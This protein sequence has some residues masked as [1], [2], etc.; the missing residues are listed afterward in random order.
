MADQERG[1]ASRHL[2]LLFEAGT[3]VGLT[4]GQLLDLFLARRD[5]AAFSALVERHGTMVLRVCLEVL[6]NDHD[7]HDAFQ[8]TFVV[9][10]RR[11]ASINRRDSL[12]SW[13]YGVARRVSARERSA[14]ARR[15]RHER[16]W[17]AMHVEEVGDDDPST[18]HLGPLLHAE[19]AR[20][21]ERFRAPI[22]LCYLEAR[23]YEEAAGLLCCPVGTIKSRLATAR[24]RLRRRLLRLEPASLA[25]SGL[26]LP[27][28][29]HCTAP[30]PA[31][32]VE[33]AVAAAAGRSIGTAVS[34]MAAGVVRSMLMSRLMLAV[35]FVLGAGSVAGI[36]L[37]FAWARVGN[38]GP[39]AEPMRSGEPL[40]ARSHA[41]AQ[42]DGATAREVGTVFFRVVDRSTKQPLPGV[43]LTVSI[44]G[45]VRSQHVTD[46]SGRLVIPLP[47][48]KIDRL[49]VTARKDGLAPMKVQLRGSGAAEREIPRTYALAMGPATSIGGIVRDDLGQPIEGVWVTIPEV[50]L[51]EG[52]REIPDLAGV[53]ARTDREG[54]W[55]ID[56]IPA[57]FDLGDLQF[58]FSREGFLSEVDSSRYQPKATPEQLR[59]RSGVMVLARGVSISGRVLNQEGRPIAGASVGLGRRDWNRKTKTDDLGRFEFAAAAAAESLFT[60]EASGFA[61]E[62]RSVL[63]RDGLP[64]FEFRLGSGRAI[65]G[66]VADSQG[67]PLAD[68][69]IAVD[70]RNGLQNLNWRTKSDAAGRFAWDTAP[71]FRV[72]LS[73]WKE[74]YRA[75]R[76][77]IEPA[78]KEVDFKLVAVSPLRIRGIVTD[79]ATGR[80]I[81]AFTVVPSV[82]PGDILMLDF[83]KTHHGG[84]Y[85]FAEAKNGQPYSIRIEARG[86]LPAKSPEYPHDGGD[87]VFSARLKKGRW[88]EGIVRGRDGL[89]L[90]GAEVV[91]A[92]GS[93]IS[94]FAGKPRQ[95][96]HHPHLRTEPDGRFSF[97]PPEG[98]ARIV[99]VHA[100][101]YAEAFVQ[102]QDEGCN[103]TLQPWGRIE[104]TLL[105]DG[106]PLARETIVAELDEERPE[107]LQPRIGSENRAQTDEQGHFVIDRL[108]PG[109]ARVFWQPERH[110]AR[111]HPDRFYPPSFIN[112]RAGE[113]TRLEMVH[114][115]EPSLLGRV[116]VPEAKDAPPSRSTWGAY[117]IVKPPDVPYPPKLIEEERQVWLHGWRFT[118][119]GRAYRH[120]KRG[121]GHSLDLQDD[122]SFRVDAIQPGTYELHIQVRGRAAFKREFVVP[123][124]V[125]KPGS[126]VVDLGVITPQNSL[127]VGVVP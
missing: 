83:A 5:E 56:L 2:R 90:A 46:E 51:L 1:L 8:A 104:G 121:F 43:S 76:L 7:A 82:H 124:P 111:K 72:F 119:A 37:P 107:S 86:Y 18:E 69:N 78:D 59:S 27:E 64:P 30:V 109:E 44:N 95:T 63:L 29:D 19:V 97:S 62:V 6:G 113:P 67:R 65:R 116:V 110:G 20:L 101:G 93:G 70:S 112:V 73:A 33:A 10:A 117:L 126:R 75:V 68:A 55:H 16:N 39:A 22:V 102:R 50:S 45:K 106:K 35:L 52:G 108:P 125:S 36:S 105:V 38:G 15:R 58:T 11:A 42:Q 98:D 14:S 81:E 87:Q 88:V 66:S 94:V 34:K 40:P 60:V 31:A 61:P 54:R 91:L 41:D 100:Q 77:A 23:T 127:P 47:G 13:L 115:G 92:T 48:G 9:L 120:A 25:G 123:E 4:D 21:P 85:V 103:L 99:A 79:A 71:T 49:S 26:R 32:L 84:R 89:P 57:D 80:P 12:A 96:D 53:S 28:I 118:D 17:A 3:V 24:L 114:D 122:G 74:G